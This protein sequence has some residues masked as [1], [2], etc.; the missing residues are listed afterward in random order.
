M[1]RTNFSDDQRAEIF[2][3]DRATCSYSGRNLW[4]ADYGIDPAY[5][6]DWAD[7]IVPAS[8]GGKSVVENGA[9]AS[10]LYNYL[11]GNRQQRL[12][13]F[14]RGLPTA[15][16]TIHVGIIDPLVTAQLH[17]FRMLHIS[18]WF[19]NRA[20]WHV[21]IGITFEYERRQGLNRS[22][23]YNYYAAASL[24]CLTKWRQ[25]VDKNSIRSL[26]QR[27][28]V[29]PTAEVDQQQLLEIRHSTSTRALIDTMH[30]LFP[31]YNA[32]AKAL[33]SLSQAEDVARLERAMDRVESHKDIPHRIR[34][35]LMRYAKS[36][37]RM[38]Q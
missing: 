23:D 34:G 1:A 4:I 3:L 36:L 38:I 20:M 10:W 33:L 13:I 28:L 29:S 27:R 6:V 21:W 32:S 35:R 16:H 19:L 25:L 26:E 15:E 14:H 18:D 11:R 12:M 17:R 30:D 5:A 31:S 8:C 37:S 22:R 24:K 9:A 2:V 7:H